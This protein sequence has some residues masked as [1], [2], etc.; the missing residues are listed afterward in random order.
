MVA[1]HQ[2]EEVTLPKYVGWIGKGQDGNFPEVIGMAS[3]SDEGW[4]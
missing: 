2:Q 1:V 4:D 3:L